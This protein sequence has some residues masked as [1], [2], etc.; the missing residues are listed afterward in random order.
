MNAK[1]LSGMAVVLLGTSAGWETAIG[2]T[3]ERPFGR[4]IEFWNRTGFCPFLRAM[5]QRRAETTNWHKPRTISPINAQSIS[6]GETL[7]ISGRMGF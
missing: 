7:I 2:M 5:Q 6:P 4:S 1:M 3:T